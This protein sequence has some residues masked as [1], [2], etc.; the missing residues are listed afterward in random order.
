[1]DFSKAFNKVSNDRLLY[2]LDSADINPQTRIWISSFLS[3]QSQSVVIDGEQSEAMPVTSGVPQ[4]SVL[5]L[6]LFPF[7]INDLHEYT[8]FVPRPALRRRHNN[9]PYY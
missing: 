8:S 2:K 1:M 3:N 4:G 6:I 5:G 9:L 7:F